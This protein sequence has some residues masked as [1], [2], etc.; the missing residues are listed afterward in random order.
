[1]L[2]FTLASVALAAAVL[3]VPPGAKAEVADTLPP[4]IT[5]RAVEVPASGRPLVVECDIADPSGV[6]E[7]LVYWRE[8]GAPEFTHAKLQ[9]VDGTRY[10]AT[11]RLPAGAEAVEY[12]L[13]AYDGKGN[14]PARVG[15]QKLPLKLSLVRAPPPPAPPAPAPP[16]KIVAAKPSRP[17][18]E[19][20]LFLGVTGG[21]G[22]S[23]RQ[24]GTIEDLILGDL[25]KDA[26]LDVVG[27]SDI[28]T[29]LGVEAKKEAL[30]CDEGSCLTE[31]AGAVGAPLVARASV[32]RLGSQTV[33]AL[34]ILDAEKAHELARPTRSVSTDD[35]LPDALADLVTEALATMRGEKYTPKRPAG[36]RA[37]FELTV[38]ANAGVAYDTATSGTLF[39]YGGAAMLAFGNILV[40]PR[41]LAGSDGGAGSTSFGAQVGYRFDPNRIPGWHVPSPAGLHLSIAIATGPAVRVASAAEGGTVFEWDLRALALAEGEH[42][43]LQAGVGSH[44][45]TIPSQPID[46]DLA[47]GWKF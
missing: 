18:R 26:R 31:L 9:H 20:M 40:V 7:P 4:E 36:E 37:P 1:M 32:G 12:F 47:V 16:P 38:L 44:V 29:L 43:V 42:L 15:S 10:R 11:I 5:P 17:Q 23:N 34:S 30:G 8:A 28:A 3:L 27:K 2:R 25:Q 24:L 6:Y 14:G 41:V 21:E 22:F 39:Q 46:V 33:V 13:E 19:R 35:E 45:E